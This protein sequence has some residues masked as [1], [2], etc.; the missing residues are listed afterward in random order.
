MVEAQV[1]YHRPRERIHLEL[2]IFQEGLDHGL[3]QTL[4]GETA[5]VTGRDITHTG[6]RGLSPNL[7][8]E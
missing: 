8:M 1:D 7:S 4:K 2:D 3:D 6:G 5:L